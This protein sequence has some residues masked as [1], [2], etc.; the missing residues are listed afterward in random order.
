MLPREA[1]GISM[2]KRLLICLALYL[3]AACAPKFE[4]PVLSVSSVQLTGGNF[5]Q[6]NFLVKFEVQNPNKR[7]L[8]VQ[9]LKAELDVGGQ[10]IA[11]GL[12]NQ[13][14]VVPPMGESEFDMT[15][16]ANMAAALLSLA[17]QRGDS[18]DYELSG[19]ANLDLPFLREVPFHQ[20]GSFSLKG[21]H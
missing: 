19:S 3:L 18:I 6:Q 1:P 15:I 11:S 12:S 14:F 10:R 9:G 13:A 7:A 20:S 8:P 4:R 17:N 16:T 2:T 21:I 5:F